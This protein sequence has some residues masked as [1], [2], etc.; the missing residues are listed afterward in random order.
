MKFL[1]IQPG[2]VKKTYANITLSK[3]M[4][5]Y[6]PKISIEEGIPYFIKWYKKYNKIK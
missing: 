4:L 2:D 1:D 6:S 5:S 3:K